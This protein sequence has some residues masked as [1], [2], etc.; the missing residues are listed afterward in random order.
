MLK[1]HWEEW[2]FL[3]VTNTTL[4]VVRAYYRA[5]TSKIFDEA[6]GLLAPNLQVKVQSS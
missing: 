2:E 5:W 6:I 4:S 3:E 1:V